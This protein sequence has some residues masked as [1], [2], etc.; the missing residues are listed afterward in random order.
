MFEVFAVLSITLFLSLIA[1]T[2]NSNS[3]ETLSEVIVGVLF[4]WVVV[5]G[6]TFLIA[7]GINFLWTLL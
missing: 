2:L 7:L 4:L 1:I 3:G 6:F 5:N